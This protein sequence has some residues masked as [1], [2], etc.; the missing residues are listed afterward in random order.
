[1]L[2]SQAQ[3]KF[4]LQVLLL[5]KYLFKTMRFSDKA[6]AVAPAFVKLLA[7]GL[8]DDDEH[9]PMGEELH[10][11]LQMKL[12]VLSLIEY[13][14][15]LQDNTWLYEQI[16]AFPFTMTGRAAQ[17]FDATKVRTLKL[18]AQCILNLVH[19]C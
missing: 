1:M 15:D 17:Y 7:L 6:R 8:H 18:L 2:K 3:L 12:E 11:I 9:G 10:R 19:L 16:R 14:F 13:Y 4:R 5:T